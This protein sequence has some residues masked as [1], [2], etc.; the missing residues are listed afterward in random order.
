MD[1][2]KVVKQLCIV[3]FMFCVTLIGKAQVGAALNFDGV[4]DVVAV[5]NISGFGSSDFT[6]ESWAKFNAVQLEASPTIIS[7]KVAGPIGITLFMNNSGNGFIYLDLANLTNTFFPISTMDVRDNAWHHYAVTRT[8]NL[9]TTY[10]DGV[11]TSSFTAAVTITN[12]GQF[13]LGYNSQ[14]VFSH[15]VGS[16]DEV[17]VWNLARTS[18]DISLY[19]N[20]EIATTAGSLLANY[21][22]NQGVAGGNNA[23]IT[24]LTDLSGNVYTG[25]LTSFALTGASS[26]WITPGGVTSGSTAIVPLVAPGTQTN[27]LCNGGATGIV[28]VSAGGGTGPY[29]YTW[30][31]SGGTASISTGLTAGNYSCITTDARTCTVVAGFVVTEPAGALATGTTITNVLCNGASTGSG[32]ITSSGG[33]SPYTYLWSTAATTSV[34]SGLNAGVRTATVTDANGCTDSKSI[35]IT[36]PTTLNTATAVSNVLCNG[37]SGSATITP[38]GGTAPY[39]YLWTSGATTSVATVLLA[40]AYSAT[41]TDANG[42]TSIKATTITQP[43]TLTTNTLGVN[44]TCNGGTGSAT[45]SPAGGTTP[46]TYLWSSGAT[47]S[48]VTGALA[49]VYTATV[50]DANGCVSSKGTNITQPTALTTNTAVINVS[51]NG[52]TG[53]ATITVS[54]GTSPYSYLWSSGPTASVISGVVA[55]VYTATV[56]DANSCA[57]VKAV[58]ISQP[59]TALATSTAVSNVVCNGGTGS[60]TITASGGTSPY[61]YLWSNGATSSV[62]TVL[63]AG[64]Y[65]ATVTDFNGCT[66]NKAA[67][68]TQPTALSTSTAFT[69]VL[70][71]GGTGSATITAA[72]GTGAYSYLWSNG[73]TT[74]IVSGLLNGAYTATVTDANGCT[75]SKGVSIS[76]P[77]ALLTSTNVTNVLCNGGTGS[78]TITASGGITPYTYLWSTTAVTSTVSGLVAGAYTATVTDANGCTSSKA[79]TLSQPAALVTSTAVSNALCNAG[80]G[81]ATITASGGTSPYTYLWTSGSTSSVASVLLA[82]AY[83][84]TVTDANGC[85]SS[86]SANISQPAALNTSTAVT[87][88][89]C[90][91]ATGSATLT[92]S[93]GTSPYS[94]LWSSAATTSVV[95]GI[96]AGAYSATVTDA[97]GCTNSN[98]ITIS[99]PAALLTSTAVTNVLCNGGTGS[100]TVTASGGT[101]PYT[102][103]WSS[104]GTTSVISGMISGAYSATVTDANSCTSVKALNIIQPTALSTST[105]IT[106]VLCNGG[107]TG[108]ATV[109]ASGGTGTFTYL[110]STAATT[111]VISGLNIGVRTVTVTDANSCTSSKSVTITQPTALTTNTAVTNVLC[112]GGTGSA[113]ITASGGTT[114]Y[115]YLWS[116]AS[117]SSVVSGALA[118]AY[119]G[120]VTDANGCTSS[121]VSTITQPAVA[122]TTSTAGINVLCNG[123]TGSATITASGGT[124]PYTYLWSSGATTSVISGVVAAAYTATVTDANGCTSSK[125]I[126]IT[127]PSALSTSTAVT[128]V[129]CNGGSTGS[130]TVTASGGSGAYSYLWSTAATTSVVSGLGSGAITV[131]VTDANS[132]TSTKGVTI[133]QP[134]ALAT[135]TSVTN[136]L[137][138]GGT[139]SA[140]IAASAGT[141]PY[142]YLWSSGSTSSVLTGALAGAYTGTVTDANGCS[143]SKGVTISQPAALTTN[144]TVINVLCN[145]GTGSATIT[146]AGGTGAYTYLW[147]S[148][149]TTSVVPA[150]IAGVYTATVTDANNCTSSKAVTIT[151]PSA[152][153]TSTTI[154]NVLCNGGSTGSAT[155]T[156][157]GGTGVYTYLWSTA[158]TTSVIS[159]LNSGVRTV[160]VTDAN[161]CASSKSVTITQPTALNTSTAV[162]NIL[163]NGGTGSATLTASGGTTPYSYLWSSG[164]TTSVVSG[165]LA[166]AYTAT[167]TDANGCTSSK[168]AALNA[169]PAAL[170]LTAV[171]SSPTLCVG[172]SVTLTANGSG[173]TGAFTYTW[174]S[175]P[176]TSTAVVSPTVNSTYTVNGLD[177]NN[178]SISK[179]VSVIVSTPTVVVSNG[180]ICAGQSFTI[181]PSGASTYT[182][183]SGTAVVSPTTT[184]NYTVNGTAAA[185]GCIDSETLTVTVNTLPSVSIAVSS[186]VICSGKTATL[187]ASGAGSYLWNTGPSTA[188]ISV[189]PTVTTTYTV[190]GTAAV[191]GCT[192]TALQTVSVNSLPVVAIVP[193]STV[194]C[195]GNSATLSASGATSF[196]WNTGPS[197]SSISVNPA[198]TTNY[199]VIGTDATTSCSNSAVQSVSVNN[200][201]VVTITPSSTV[202]CAGKT[203][204]LTASGASTYVWDNAAI[205]ASISVSPTLTTS[206]TVTGTATTGCSNTAVRSISVN[207]LPAVAA[208]ATSTVLCAGKPSTLTASGANTYV[209]STGPATSS[210]VVTPTTSTL[211]TVTGTSATTGCSNTA[212][213]SLSI[214]ALPSITVV[215]STSI[216]C[217]GVSTTLTASGASSYVWNTA[218]TLIS[219]S[220]NPVVTTNYTVTGTD[221]ITNCSNTAV[222][223]VSVNALPPISIASSNAV[224]CLN[225]SATL[226]ASGGN[227]YLWDSGASSAIIVVTPSINTTYTVVG[228]SAATGCSNTAVKTISVNSL[229]PMA[230]VITNSVI[231]FG[232]TTTLTASGSTTYTWNTGSTTT[233]IVV[234]PT[235]SSNYTITGTAAAT[236]CTNTA[237]QSVSVNALPPLLVSPTSSV[238]CFGNSSTLTA[239]GATSYLWNTSSTSASIVV[240]PTATTNYTVN[241]TDALTSCSVNVV[242]TVSV[243]ALPSV[244]ISPS[245][246]VICIG[247]TATLAASG[248]TTYVWD[249]GATTSSIA[250]SPTTTT[251][252]TVIG[253]SALTSCSNTAVRSLSVNFLPV[254][255]IAPSTTVICFGKTTSL[256]AG[257]T[258][259]YTW[260]TNSTLTTVVV[261]PSVS[262]NYTVTGTAAVTGCSNTAVQ[263]ISVNSLPT[264]TI[265]T[266]ST[267]LCAGKSA[268]LT[269]SGT[270]TYLW[271]TQ[272]STNTMVVVNPN[273]SLNYTVTGTDAITSCS[274]TA[275]KSISVN[276]LPAVTASTPSSTICDGLSATI[277]SSGASTYTWIPGA[278]NGATVT[279]S[280]SINTS[281][282]VT[283][284]SAASGCTNQ[285]VKT[286]SVNTTP[287]VTLV[288]STPSICLG[289]TATLTA[290]G[291][292]TYTLLPGNVS[293]NAFTLSPASTTQYT[294]IGKN[295]VNCFNLIPATSGLQVNSLTSI[296]GV[297]TST[298][299]QV[300]GNVILLRYKP[301]LSKWDSITSSLIFSSTYNFPAVPSG[302]YAVVAY[303][304]QT[305]MAETYGPSVAGWKD[306]NLIYHQCVANSVQNINVIQ[307]QNA[308][309][310][311]ASISGKIT[312]G[313][314]YW[315]PGALGSPISNVIVKCGIYGTGIIAQRSRT[316]SQGQYTLGTLPANAS[317]QSYYLLVDI[318]G[319]DT[320]GT[321]HR[322]IVTGSENYTN[323][324]FVVDSARIT[325]NNLTVGVKELT[326]ANAKLLVYPNPARDNI[327]IQCDLHTSEDVSI[328][329]SDISGRTVKTLLPPSQQQGEVT[330]I[331]NISDVIPGIYFVTIKVA[332]EQRTTKVIITQ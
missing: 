191:T 72:G 116:N 247:K 218:S 30:L 22:F 250:V 242:Q 19:K 42:C 140:T 94:Y 235:V 53:S 10:F 220:V 262:S 151:Q 266:T 1:L 141:T 126:T 103:L 205:T 82:G 73:A 270:D 310:G 52:G 142:S 130:A 324:N 95:S 301:I 271:S 153:V 276:A 194:I 222:Q 69:S 203:A 318:P 99:Q 254:V 189:G 325:P 125:P 101:T 263:S 260:N 208:A 110:W 131:T 129:L 233:S 244:F 28:A 24:S 34:I 157:S 35:T 204:T 102:Y 111:S 80:T 243:N 273:F 108:S 11:N 66:S 323:L 33:T 274:N 192:N 96:L 283:G 259:T 147:S 238:L 175:G 134:V 64:A 297:V 295:T 279:V 44:I 187:T 286:I 158:A 181:N 7:N 193:S 48:F 221:V 207:A 282:T 32:T 184:T 232:K 119:T 133:T 16:I 138:N 212:V 173:G 86:K 307:I 296:S 70:C 120:T 303:P 149:A 81:S 139:G 163:C 107:S 292:N 183:S 59:A 226:T 88:V 97:N 132:C 180:T 264:M 159:G 236:G 45:I 317:A 332:G 60:A 92:A 210:I 202:I 93:G 228:T 248:A 117:T 148:G 115:T 14:N 109:T 162:T 122:L 321:Y 308:I 213:L 18:C 31:P 186:S 229:P 261:S 67:T 171:S 25:T 63:L 8:G 231:C 179:T 223:T 320:N 62:A 68:L 20:V 312:R 26:N 294:V 214:N 113:T 127:Q 280:P 330:V 285:A 27:V 79:A 46:Y 176:T 200:L 256:T 152:L 201:P 118:G 145:G 227:F 83:S 326:M 15:M 104:G 124:S 91:G 112:N 255:T 121:K 188:S 195:I 74:S 128:N 29:T 196:L 225:N 166:G 106:N 300:N 311:K 90:N 137:C 85:S 315:Q 150:L 190:T 174:V 50:T 290:S 56:T 277:V 2:R 43:V 313:V 209:W 309:K 252:Y 265:T 249:N 100:A 3:V 299:S 39:S 251:S 89:L 281:Y 170:T 245:S 37:G 328:L 216:I 272:G 75:S 217:V 41:V 211:Y 199:T 219:I 36:Q 293:G 55:G 182:Y 275:V 146:A 114:P 240:S 178:C 206:Y 168:G 329:L 314:G 316:N 58:T 241:G 319:L 160:T 9:Y 76:Q 87:N 291:A 268:T 144:T 84:A 135:S 198:V 4:D 258:A 215:P 123:G 51:C 161:S 164:P 224:I 105:A 6:I 284:T 304:F 239:T 287:T 71:N 289:S 288:S 305:D 298:V 197:T 306:A 17:R 40:G 61:T 155:V 257:G 57:S 13:Q 234:S 156:A 136:V 77:A 267:V 246:T 65:S 172:S 331:A 12:T 169:A 23:G 143:S 302:T 54:G 269:V 47:T 78:A 322:I 38:S 230:I 185:T 21:H 327:T 98:L 154:T 278:L 49:G 177:A 5:P 253:T 165:L 237:I 167:V